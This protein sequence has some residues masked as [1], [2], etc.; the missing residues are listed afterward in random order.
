MV[1]RLCF[2]PRSIFEDPLVISLTCLFLRRVCWKGLT[3]I[4]G[5]CLFA[6]QLKLTCYWRR[7]SPYEHV[8]VRNALETRSSIWNSEEFRILKLELISDLC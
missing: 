2:W 6:W 5:E 3:L 7:K 1:D 4:L 8:L